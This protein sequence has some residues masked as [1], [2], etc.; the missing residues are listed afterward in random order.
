MN[1]KIGLFAITVSSAFNAIF[2]G[3]GV[4]FLLET[5]SDDVVLVLWMLFFAVNQ[6]ELAAAFVYLLRFRKRN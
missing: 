4:Y 6:I 5:P 3:I 1:A 2:L